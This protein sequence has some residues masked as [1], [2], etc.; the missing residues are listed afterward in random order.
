M[1]QYGHATLGKTLTS[2]FTLFADGREIKG[3]VDGESSI[4]K[5]DPSA[6]PFRDLASL[7]LSPAA[8]SSAIGAADELAK[9]APP[10]DHEYV[11]HLGEKA[12]VVKD[13][14]AFEHE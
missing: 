4:A 7:D 11:K 3:T 14:G 8:G 9:N 12:R 5:L 2:P 10:V 13:L 6:S 1:N